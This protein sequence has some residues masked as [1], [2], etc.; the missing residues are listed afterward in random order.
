MCGIVAPSVLSYARLKPNSWSTFVA[1]LG[2]RDR[3]S[4]IR[5]CPVS[6][7][8]GADVSRSFNFEL[9]APDAAACPYLALGALIRA[10]TAGLDDQLL[11]PAA[12]RPGEAQARGAPPL[13]STLEEALQALE[14]DGVLMGEDMKSPYLM[15]KRGEAAHVAGL[16]LEA[17]AALYARIY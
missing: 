15:L 5:I 7:R 4:F 13:P 1:N 2:W 8:P 6:D 11:R 10:G 14:A 12:S 9:R 3:E 17:L 16:D